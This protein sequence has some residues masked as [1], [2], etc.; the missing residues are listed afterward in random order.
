[1]ASA[2]KN[3]FWL[4]IS[5]IIALILLFIAYTQL[6]RYLGPYTSGQYQF[7]LSYVAIFGVIIDF[8][9]QQYIIKKISESPSEVKKYFQN[10]LAV[11]VVL[12]LFIY[13]LLLTIAKLNN[14]EPIVFNAIAV[15]GLGTALNGLTYPF[16]SVMSAFYDLRKVALINFINSLINVATI[17]S[18]IYFHKSIVLLSTNL[19]VFSAIGLVLYHGFVKK[20]IPKPEVFRAVLSLD[21]SLVKKIMIAAFPFALL[22]GFST[23]YNRIDIILITN[24][25]GYKETGLYT[26]AY[27]FFDLMG[28]FPAIVSHSIYPVFTSLMAQRDLLS[29]RDMIE[30]YLRFMMALALPIGVGGMLLAKPIILVL[31]GQ[32][33]AEA[34]SVLAI[35][36]WAPAVLF[37]YIVANSLVISQ[38]TKFAVAITGANVFINIVGNLLLLPHI[39]IRGAA[40]MTVASEALQGIFYFYF[41]HRK[42]TKFHFFSLIWK[43]VLASLVMGVGVRVVGDTNLVLSIVVGIVIYAVMMLALRFFTKDDLVFFKNFIKP[44][45]AA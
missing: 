25:L 5:R 32:E 22:V 18:V 30:K 1:M 11:E 9:L 20:Y 40:I 41:I 23:I 8:G 19:L 7:V 4:T 3:I 39:G 45:A 13:G 21:W 24:V 29:V 31:A 12:A 16:L 37:I 17:F 26:A 2:S 38:L 27:K 35:L 34:A 10:F 33:Y 43:P 28:F 14:Y 15:A 6:F 44:Q 36:V 42:I